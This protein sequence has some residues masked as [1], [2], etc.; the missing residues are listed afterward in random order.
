MHVFWAS[1]IENDQGIRNIFACFIF[2]SKIKTL[3]I[4]S[5]KMLLAHSVSFKF[6]IPEKRAL[7]IVLTQQIQNNRK[8]P[9]PKLLQRGAY[10]YKPFFL[11]LKTLKLAYFANT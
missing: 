11:F 2:R 7:E 6:L 8:N 1:K 10:N 9:V 5:V 3:Q 4:K